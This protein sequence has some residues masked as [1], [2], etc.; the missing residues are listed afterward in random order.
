M[1]DTPLEAGPAVLPHASRRLG[2]WEQLA[3]T[4]FWF[5]SNVHWGAILT[6]LVQSQV[7]VMVGDASK[8]AGVGTAIAIGSI[9]GILV[10]PLLGAWSDRVRL[11]VGRRRPFMVVGT[12]LNLVALAGMATLPFL[13][14]GSL[15]SFTGAYWLYV[16]AYLMANFANNVA[17]A[18]YTALMPD[19]VP[20]EQR[21]SVAGWYGLM[22]LLGNGVGMGLASSMVSQQASL[23]DFQG[24]I[25]R[26]YLA[27]GFIL[28]VGVAV[29]VLSTREPPLTTAPKPFHWGTFLQGFVAPFRSRDFRWVFLTRMLMSMGVFSVQ[30][31]LMFYLRDVVKDFSVSGRLLAPTPELAVLGMLGLLL[32]LALPSTLIAGKLSDRYG[33]KRVVYVAG[34]IQAVVAMGLILA[35][36]YLAALF[37]GALFGIGYGAYESVNWALATDVLPDMDDAAKDMGI[38]HMSLTVPQLLATPIAG[39]LLDTFN[40]VG[41][42]GG[43]PTLG[44]TVIFS[45]AILY[46]GLG[47]VFVA[48]VKKAS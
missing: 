40:A 37:I 45:V 31:F 2:T 41:T 43:R 16:G 46:F 21:G 19:V 22:T 27:I 24:Q 5:S 3:L 15:W 44:Y 10:P 48:R 25:H 1:I 23:G 8:G 4:F 6:I 7:L 35:D 14:T 26:V 17:T 39:W 32:L 18:P 9:T 42:R 33:R 28:V 34:G 13:K 11:R 38:W 47:T 12:A 29:T 20:P 36:Q 30:S